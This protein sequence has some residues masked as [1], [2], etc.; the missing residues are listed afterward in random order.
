ML[1]CNLKGV[2]QRKEIK[3]DDDQQEE[4]ERIQNVFHGEVHSEFEEWLQRSLVCN[5]LILNKQSIPQNQEYKH[6]KQLPPSK[7]IELP[8]V[9]MLAL[10]VD[11]LTCMYVLTMVSCDIWV[12]HSWIRYSKKWS[13]PSTSPANRWFCS[14]HVII[15][16]SN[17]CSCIT[18]SNVLKIQNMTETSK[19]RNHIGQKWA[20]PIRWISSKLD[21]H[22]G[23]IGFHNNSAW[24]R[25]NLG[26]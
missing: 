11:P 24:L 9:P 3:G 5:L 7:T 22:S 15:F 19:L 6:P 21:L 20:W 10:E 4:D 1:L 25:V 14:F 8:H 23:I 18:I 12:A 17:L 26:I 16:R 13:I 2:W